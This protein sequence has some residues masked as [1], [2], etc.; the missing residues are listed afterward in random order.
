MNYLKQIK[1]FLNKKCTFSELFSNEVKALNYPLNPTQDEIRNVILGKS[2]VSNGEPIQAVANYLRRGKGT[3]SVATD[4]RFL[5][6]SEEEILKKYRKIIPISSFQN[7][8]GQGLEHRVYLD[9][10]KKTVTKINNGYFYSYWKNYFNSLLLNN[11]F[12]PDTAYN[13]IGFTEENG[14]IFPVVKQPYIE[15]T[16]KTDLDQVRK[17]ASHNGFKSTEDHA[18]NYVN[19][20]LG[21]KL[22][23]L[24]SQ[25]VIINNGYLY[26]IDTVFHIHPNLFE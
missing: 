20:E 9:S 2:K 13:L 15:A 23:D 6:K 24:H 17:F 8:I 11:Y 16:E 12:F 21:I 14:R 3:S 5:K 4:P 22:E 10:D 7:K 19:E 1:H 26:F 18:F 25:N